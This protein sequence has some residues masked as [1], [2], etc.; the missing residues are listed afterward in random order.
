VQH[1]RVLGFACNLLIPRLNRLGQA[2]PAVHQSAGADPGVQVRAENVTHLADGHAQSIMKPGTE[3][4]DVVPQRGIGHG[5]GNHR[6]DMLFAV[7][8][9]IPM[10]RMLG[11][12]R[13]DLFGNIFDDPFA[14]PLAALKFSAAAGAGFKAMLDCPVDLV[15]RL[16]SRPGVTIPGPRLFA[17]FLCRRLLI[18]RHHPR[19]RGR[20]RRLRLQAQLLNLLAGR[21]QSQPH[22]FGPKFGQP[23]RL[24]FGQLAAKQSRQQS[25]EFG[26][27]RDRLQR[28]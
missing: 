20:G 5:V 22:R 27:L 8:A 16:A 11:D 6:L 28:E 21:Q 17:A 9:V 7:R 12:N 3:R 19:R 4:D 15:R 1:R 2:P 24:G 14:L 23:C 10:N 26:L 18:N 13:G 25:I